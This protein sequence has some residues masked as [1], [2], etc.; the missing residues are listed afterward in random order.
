[1]ILIFLLTFILISCSNVKNYI[2]QDDNGKKVLVGNFTWAEWQKEMNWHIEGYFE[3]FEFPFAAVSYLLV[4]DPHLRDVA[5][6]I[7]LIP[8]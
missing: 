3:I 5:H 4:D 2:K 1:M 6:L 7:K 8:P